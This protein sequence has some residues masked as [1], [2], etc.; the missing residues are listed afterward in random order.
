[1]P[2]ESHQEAR[3]L[4]DRAAVEGISPEEQRWLNSHTAQCAECA[5]YAELS[6]RVLRALDAFA[7]D[8]DP[9]GPLRVQEALRRRSAFAPSHGRLSKAVPVA[10]GLTIMGSLAMYR[11]ASWLA[12]R[13][14][15]AAPA[16]Q[17][18][19]AAFWF[20]PSIALTLLL[21]FPAV[22]LRD[23]SNGDGETL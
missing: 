22:F 2:F 18:A 21:S 3:R 13:W 5:G 16:W 6:Q 1:M 9:A 15:V 7:F 12:A 23:R 11:P 8:F 4:L 20:L 10:I 17:I 19:F 14:S